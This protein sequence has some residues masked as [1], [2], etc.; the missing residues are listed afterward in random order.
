MNKLTIQSRLDNQIDSVA[1]DSLPVAQQETMSALNLSDSASQKNDA[2]STLPDSLWSNLWYGLGMLAV[3]VIPPFI[4]GVSIRG[5]IIGYM[6]VLVS[7]YA[8]VFALAM[9]KS[10]RLSKIARRDHR[11]KYYREK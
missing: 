5:L 1:V 3:A 11:A 4:P 6:V 2:A 8:L 9:A 7:I 10:L